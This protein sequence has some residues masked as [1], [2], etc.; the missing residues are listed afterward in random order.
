MM[1]PR[2][3]RP[4]RLGPH[5]RARQGRGPRRSRRPAGVERGGLSSAQEPAGAPTCYGGNTPPV[6]HSLEELLTSC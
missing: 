5:Q 2:G 6:P 4:G 3:P 1:R